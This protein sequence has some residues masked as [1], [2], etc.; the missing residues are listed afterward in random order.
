[1]LEEEIVDSLTSKLKS[2]LSLK[3]NLDSNYDE[4]IELNFY[5]FMLLSNESSLLKNWVVEMPIV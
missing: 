5:K 4:N 1:M 2:G 3:L